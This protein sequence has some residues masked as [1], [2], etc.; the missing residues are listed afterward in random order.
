MEEKETQETKDTNSTTLIDN[1]NSAAERLEKANQKQEELIKRQ[2][3]LYTKEKLGG[4]SE[5]KETP[6][7]KEET[8]KEYS[9]RIDKEIREGKY[10]G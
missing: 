3:S 1:A 4:S 9:E 5:I 2:E 6:K 8:D 7:P 10:N